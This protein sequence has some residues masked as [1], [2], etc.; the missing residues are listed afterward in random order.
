MAR[1]AG[2]ERDAKN[3][4]EIPARVIWRERVSGSLGLALE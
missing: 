3:T 1:S 2:E 4:E